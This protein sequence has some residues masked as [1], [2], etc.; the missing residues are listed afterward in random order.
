MR[1]KDLL[2][3]IKTIAVEMGLS[4]WTFDVEGTDPLCNNACE[5]VP[6]HRRT[7][8]VLRF[9][10]YFHKAPAEERRYLVIHE[11]EHVWDSNLEDVIKSGIAKIEKESGIDCSQLIESIDNCLEYRVD[12]HAKAFSKRLP[13]P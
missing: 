2:A 1:K 11:L 5:V 8:A 9:S 10:K 12:R 3:Y 13:L 4:E 6:S 7:H